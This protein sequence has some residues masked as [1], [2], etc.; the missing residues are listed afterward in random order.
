MGDPLKNMRLTP[1]EYQRLQARVRVRVGLIPMECQRLKT[2]PGL[3][4]S[5]I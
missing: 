3:G 1:T 2:T 5:L 4:L